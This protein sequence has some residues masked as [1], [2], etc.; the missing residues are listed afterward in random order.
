M[1]R[2]RILAGASALLIGTA[3]LA[4]CN[5]GGGSKGTGT[6]GGV[7]IAK[8]EKTDIQLVAHYDVGLNNEK[9][10]IG[11]TVKWWKENVG[12]NV[13]L[14]VVSADIYPTKIMGMISANNSPDL[15]L[16]RKL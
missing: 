6:Y 7:D 14:N 12:G 2:R 13:S 16:I 10:A 9:S 11:K 8:L 15:A 1:K 4:G 3:L 5:G